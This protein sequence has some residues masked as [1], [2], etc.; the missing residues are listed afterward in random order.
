MPIPSILTI[1]SPQNTNTNISSTRSRILKVSLLNG[2]S[3]KTSKAIFTVI[4]ELYLPIFSMMIM[5]MTKSNHLECT[6]LSNPVYLTIHSLIFVKFLSL[7]DPCVNLLSDR[8]SSQPWKNFSQF[9]IC[10]DKICNN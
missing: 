10:C 1:T 5:N 7:L 4:Y 6:I 3:C 9:Y 8:T 2:M